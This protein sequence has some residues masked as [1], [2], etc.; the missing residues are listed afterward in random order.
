[1]NQTITRI[2]LTITINDTKTYDGTPLVSSYSVALASGLQGDDKL[3]AGA[4]TS[5]GSKVGSY[6]YPDTSTI[7][8]PFRTTKGIENYDV[9]YVIN[10]TITVIRIP[11]T[12][13]INDTKAYDGNPLISSYTKAVV[14]GLMPGD[15]LIS[16]AVQT[17]GPSAGSYKYPVSSG[18]LLPFETTMG[19]E[20]Y[21]VTYV[22]N[23]TITIIRVPLT[24]TINDSK[25]YDGTPLVSGYSVA[26]AS[27]LLDGD[28]LT[29]GAV[30]SA[31]SEIGSYSYP[32]TST[33]TTPFRTAKGI[34]NYDVTYNIKQSITEKIS[35]GANITIP[36]SDEVNLEMIWIEPGT[37][38]MGSPEDEVGRWADET[39]HQVTLTQGY[40]MSKYMVTEA[41]YDAITGGTR[42]SWGAVSMRWNTALNFCAKLTEQ[43]RAAGRLPEG[44]EYT[45]PTEAQ[46]E[47]ACRAGTTTALNSGKNLS[48]DVSCPEMDEVGWYWGNVPPDSVGLKKPNAWGLYDMHGYR[49]EWC[50]DWYEADYPTEPVI[51]PTGPSTGKFRVIRGG[52]TIYHA[53]RC[54]SAFRYISNPEE[55]LAWAVRLVLAPVK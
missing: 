47:Y 10:Q 52:S 1:I 19:I 21:N 29:G 34:A 31:S 9:T 24:I 20:N 12:I 41:Q 55:D 15:S 18:I 5:A 45:L 3:T 44:Y 27:G 54:R 23:Q 53:G 25:L 46:W 30:T 48:S 51:D 36:L 14:T 32:D 6:S 16:G 26:V 50:L 13:T 39:Q 28:K 42:V 2:P 7:T 4:V 11:L 35:P 40:W 8:T 22:I 43:E 49:F 17:Y 33:I 37:F 38:I